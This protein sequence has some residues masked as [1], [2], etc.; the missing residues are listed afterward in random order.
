MTLKQDMR[1]AMEDTDLHDVTLIGTDGLQVPAIKSV[2]A[3]RSPVFRRMFAGDFRERTGD[4]VS[5]DYNGL[6]LRLIV[7]Y[8]FLDE[9]DLDLLATDEEECMSDAEATLTVQARCAAHYLELTALYELITNDLGLSVVNDDKG[10]LGCVCAILRE[11]S[12]REGVESPFSL[13][14]M[15]LIQD[16]PDLC[17]LP[18]TQNQGIVGCSL[19]LLT[20]IFKSCALD[21]FVAVKC[22][23]EWKEALQINLEAHELDQ[24]HDLAKSVALNTIMPSQLA[25]L[26]PCDLFSMQ[27]FYEVYVHHGKQHL[28]QQV[29]PNSP[30]FFG[31][32]A[33]TSPQKFHFGTP[34]KAFVRGA[35]VDLANGHYLSQS[36]SH[37]KM[38][39]TYGDLP[40]E[41]RLEKSKR[42]WILSV[43]PKGEAEAL[44]LYKLETPSADIGP[45]FGAWECVDGQEPVPYIAVSPGLGFRV[46]STGPPT[47]PTAFTG[48]GAP[49]QRPAFAVVSGTATARV[50]TRAHLRRPD[51]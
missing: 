22:L 28:P 51:R 49:P 42:G 41:F 10:E 45:S 44:V 37:Y 14:C 40:S 35:G 23:K 5:M 1:T 13:I 38:E 48:F 33:E 36:S 8:C 9:I 4:T 12:L 50:R 34:G 43:S 18:K 2:L 19:A 11:L 47:P 7:K 29:T 39:G 46:G 30:T 20:M 17:L 16:W 3:I 27:Q 31:T 25:E 24:L 15:D 26:E 6:V 32:R 21:A